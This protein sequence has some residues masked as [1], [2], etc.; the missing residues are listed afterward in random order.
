MFGFSLQK[1]AI[2]VTIVAAVWYGFKLVKR[3]QDARELEA[4]KQG[5]ARAKTSARRRDKN[6]DGAAG[7][8]DAEQMVQCPVCDT[9]VPSRRPPNCGR[10]SCPY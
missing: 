6:V 8:Q 3:L 1:L 2:L 5:G 10:S 4:R 7:P 9:Y